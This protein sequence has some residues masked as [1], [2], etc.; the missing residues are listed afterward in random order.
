MRGGFFTSESN[1]RAI[2]T[3]ALAALAVCLG[4][5]RGRGGPAPP[6]VLIV[7]DTW[8]ADHVGAYGYP[9]PTTPHIDE[10]A[11]SAIRFDRAYATSSWT[12]PSM[13]SL[14]TGVYPSQHGIEHA[15][16]DPLGVAEQ[17]VLN[18]RFVTLA[19][20]LRDAGYATY[21]VSANYHMHAK[22]GMGQGFTQYRVLNFADRAEVD[23]GVKERLPLLQRSL[24]SGR[25]YFLYVHYFDP[26]HPYMPVKPF[27]DRF[28]PADAPLDEI[29]AGNAHFTELMDQGYFHANPD[30]IPMFVD[31]YDAEIA[32]CDDSVGWLLNSLPGLDDAVIVVTADHGE[33]FLEH[34][35]MSHSKDLY[36]ET[37]RVPLFIRL[38]HGRRGGEVDNVLASLVDLYPTLATLAGA[39]KPAYLAGVDLFDAW[40][41]RWN[42]NRF[43]F[44]ATR[45]AHG[46]DWNAA[47]SGNYKLLYSADRETWEL[48]DLAKDPGERTNLAEQA[49]AGLLWRFQTELRGNRR[50]PPVFPPGILTAPRDEK[51]ELSMKQLGYL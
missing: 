7:I 15:V 46:Y 8:R 42:R 20:T 13:A 37:L 27:L 40:R 25:P 2:A 28:R 47:L 44:A 31:C 43:L 14:F 11:K 51:I 21:G 19:K 12:V 33:E 49:P 35:H 32:A 23:R 34:G 26:H 48:Y 3:L 16:T 38:P 18:D 29:N 6:I 24:K 9:R 17:Q 45:R 4:G 1:W 39:K 50:R 5:C 22:F 10:F 30:K 36:S 41:Q